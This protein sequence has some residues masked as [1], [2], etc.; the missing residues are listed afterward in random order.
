[1][2]LLIGA[3][4]TIG[5]EVVPLLAELADRKDVRAL[6][7]SRESAAAI[8]RLGA[9][10]VAGDLAVPDTLPRAFADVERLMLITPFCPQQTQLELNA[11]AAAERA[12]VERVV[13]LSVLDAAPGVEV[14]MTRGHRAVE[15]ALAHSKLQ[16]T[17]LRA[18]WFASN[19]SS[20][21][22]LM[23]GGVIAYPFAE[24]RIAPIHPADVAAAIAAALTSEPPLPE[25][26]EL[27]GPQTL[28]FR[29]IADLIST[30]SGRPLELI[31]ADPADWRAGLVAFGLPAWHADALVELIEAYARRDGQVVRDGVERAL[32]RPARYFDAFL[33]EHLIP[34]LDAREPQVA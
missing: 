22:E 29:Q 13:K 4:G 6:A 31:E 20:Q 14:A 30:S 34:A 19:F 11:L 24:A 7:R 23:R 5:S 32:G 15:R 1:M 25:L 9:A 26:L 17:V 12:G 2:I 3:S 28:T 10:T 33:R 21:V 18:D 8:E 16:G 27:T